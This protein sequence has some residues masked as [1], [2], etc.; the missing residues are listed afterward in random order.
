MDRILFQRARHNDPDVVAIREA[1]INFGDSRFADRRPHFRRQRLVRFEKHFAGLPVHQLADR[2]RALEIGNPGFHLRDPR[3]HQFLV[4]RLGDALVRANQRL[5]GLRMLDF[6]RELAV[7][8]PFR[9]VPEKVAVAQSNPLHLEERAQHIFIRLDPQ[10]AQKNRA[11][12]F[13]LAVDADVEN[14]LCVVFEFHPRSAIW[15]DFPEEV[16]AVVRGLEENTGRAMQLADD[17]ALCAVNDERAVLRHQRDIAEEYFLFLDVADGLRAG[18]RIFVVNG[19]TDGDLQRRGIRHAALLAFVHVV[20]QLQRDRVAALVAECR[21]VLVERAALRAQHVA[22]LVRIGDHGRA[23][24]P[25]SGAQVVQSAQMSALALPVADRVVHEI[26]LRESAKILDRENGREHGLQARVFPLA[27]QQIHLQEALVGL[28]LDINQVRNLDRRLDF[29]E[30]Q[31]FPFP[32][33][34]ITVTMTHGPSSSGLR[35]MRQCG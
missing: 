7:N 6:S 30:V 11:E 23:A 22:R 24:I 14:V 33:D 19:E 10:R 28:L 15:N 35:R 9:R 29:S 13:A 8:Q 34:A 12:E 32:H 21:R 18:I 17:H 1:D 27:G 4:Q 25:A 16:A 26:Q 5:A 20:L 2:D 3:L 31:A